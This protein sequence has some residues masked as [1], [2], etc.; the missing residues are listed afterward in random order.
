MTLS[1]HHTMLLLFNRNEAE[2]NVITGIDT[3]YIYHHPYLV[4]N[5]KGAYLYSQEDDSEGSA[6]SY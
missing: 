2:R 4:T 1:R 6:V 5:T 3:E